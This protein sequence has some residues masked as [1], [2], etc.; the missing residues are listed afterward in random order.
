MVFLVLL[1][2]EGF[3]DMLNFHCKQVNHIGFAHQGYDNLTLPNLD[4]HDIGLETHISD[5]S[6][7]V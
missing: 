3:Y 5:D 2:S 4:L 6:L 7:C 1:E